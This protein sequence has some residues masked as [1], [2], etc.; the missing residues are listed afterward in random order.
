MSNMEFIP[1]T[2]DRNFRIEAVNEILYQSVPRHRNSICRNE[3]VSHATGSAVAALAVKIIYENVKYIKN[4]FESHAD[5]LYEEED[6]SPKKLQ[7]HISFLI[8]IRSNLKRIID[9]PAKEL[10]DM[11]IEQS[12]EEKRENVLNRAFRT[13]SGG[14]IIFD[15]QL[16][17]VLK[18]LNEELAGLNKELFDISD[19]ILKLSLA[20]RL[21]AN[22]DKNAYKNK[23]Q[24]AI[25]ST[26][27]SLRGL[28]NKVN[29]ILANISDIEIQVSEDWTN[30]I[31]DIILEDQECRAD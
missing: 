17:A 29:R 18:K 21:T 22:S 5:D 4:H 15:T 11:D 19:E 8:E 31:F 14:S 10:E 3:Y 2:R 7:E 24:P 20:K 6:F 26:A 1:A 23:I 13:L 16:P 9:E 30:D 28:K 27:A 25:R 12:T